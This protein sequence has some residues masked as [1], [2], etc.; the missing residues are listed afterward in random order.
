MSQNTTGSTFSD[1]SNLAARKNKKLTKQPWFK[2]VLIVFVALV[3]AAG[4]FLLYYYLKP[5]KYEYDPTTN[6]CNKSK[7]KYA[8]K[9]KDCKLSITTDDA[10]K[11]D[12]GKDDALV[13]YTCNK[14]DGTCNL[15]TGTDGQSLENCKN[16]CKQTVI[17][18]K[19]YACNLE[20]YLCFESDITPLVTKKDCDAKCI[21]PNDQNTPVA[22]TYA[23]NKKIGKCESVLLLANQTV[24]DADTC[25]CTC[26]DNYSGKNCE[27]YKMNLPSTVNARFKVGNLKKQKEESRA[28]FIMGTFTV[29]HNVYK[30][31]VN[32]GMDIA[33][34][35][36]PKANGS[37]TLNN[38][39]LMIQKTSTTDK[40]ATI[41]TVNSFTTTDDRVKIDD[42]MATTNY[43]WF[44]N[45]KKIWIDR[46]QKF[47]SRT[48]QGD[49]NVSEDTTYY[50]AVYL[51]LGTDDQITINFGN[52]LNTITF[53][54]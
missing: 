37:D 26:N 33:I 13:V 25:K 44:N 32:V 19:S 30:I 22:T 53:L 6:T 23:C 29:P 42:I 17:K 48:D 24:V 20:D 54:Y 51:G 35:G 11:D 12:A 43:T 9:E 18:A 3:F 15:S 36:T 14:D 31:R 49:Y 27:I 10:G 4:A 39:I 45:T 34:I 2:A 7:S 50:V 5:S 38:G 16:S 8:L 1:Q 40:L 41:S 46:G 52:Y 21:K 28:L 47:V